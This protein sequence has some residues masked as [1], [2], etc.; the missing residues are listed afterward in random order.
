MKIFVDFSSFLLTRE[1]VKSVSDEHN[2]VDSCGPSAARDVISRPRRR[3]DRPELASLRASWSPTRA[4]YRNANGN[5][6]ASFRGAAESSPAVDCTKRSWRHVF[7]SRSAFAAV[8]VNFENIRKKPITKF[9]F[10]IIISLGSVLYGLFFFEPA[11]FSPGQFSGD[12]ITVSNCTFRMQIFVT[13]KKKN[14]ESFEWLINTR[15]YWNDNR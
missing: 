2:T 8:D 3:R 7:S 11:S 12:L 5:D 6:D 10:L 14:I 4:S 1:L 15:I 13:Y 9:R